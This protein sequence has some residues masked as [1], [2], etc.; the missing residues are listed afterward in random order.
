MKARFALSR[1]AWADHDRAVSELAQAPTVRRICE[2]GGGA[3][4]LLPLDWVQQ[5][6]VEYTVLD[7]SA[8]ELKKAPAG[9]QLV[10]ADISCP[11]AGLGPF[12]LVLS[13][14]LAEHVPD[15]RVL[16]ENVFRMLAPGGLAFHFFPTLFAPPFLMN[17]LTPEFLSSWLLPRLQANRAGD[18]HHGKFPAYY[19]WCRGPSRQQIRRFESLGYIVRDYRGFFGHSGSATHGPGYYDRFPRINVA[20]QFLSECLVRRPIPAL[21]SYAWLLLERPR[22]NGQQ[23]APLSAAA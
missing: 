5:A 21:T 1:H 7:V 18:G 20:H 14:M 17:W 4:P 8:A 12:D 13:K 2:V 16:H 11:L 19:Q 22:E 3:N 9:F 23:A 15:A 6:G 10:E